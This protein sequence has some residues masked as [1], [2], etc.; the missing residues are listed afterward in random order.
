MRSQFFPD[1]EVLMEI[2]KRS[3]SA[4]SFKSLDGFIQSTS[5]EYME[6]FR[7][8]AACEQRRQIIYAYLEVVENMTGSL[9]LDSDLPYSK[10]RIEEAIL[11]E[12]ADDPESDLRRRLEIAYVQ[13]ESFIPCKDYRVIEDF[14][15]ASQ[16]AQEIADVRD[17]TSI[18]KSARIM[19]MAKGER[20]V[21]LEEE[22]HEQ[23]N[24]RHFKVR[25][26]REGCTV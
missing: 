15:D 21:K 20:A 6:L 11:Q 10:Q 8:S 18:L 9:A 14:K 5:G 12:L 3:T 4:R 1:R 17:P 25:K 26:I 2:A 7:K 24:K 23:M 22:I 13:L 19:R 16:R